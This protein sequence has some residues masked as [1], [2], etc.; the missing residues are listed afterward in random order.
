VGTLLRVGQG[1]LSPEAFEEIMQTRNREKAGP[2]VVAQG[3][4][5]KSVVYAEG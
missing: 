3:L 5:L 4:C 2:A 1:A